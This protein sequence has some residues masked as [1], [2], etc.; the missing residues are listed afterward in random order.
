MTL[1]SSWRTTLLALLLDLPSRRLRLREQIH[2]A[3]YGEVLLVKGR[4]NRIEATVYNTL[5]LNDCPDDLW[6]ALDPEAIKKS[7]RARAAIL[8]GPRYFLMDKISIADP[9]EEIFDF[10]GLQMRRLATVPLPLTSLLGG[11]QRHP[12]TE[13]AVRRTTVYVW[14]QG[15]EVYEL[16]APDGTTYV[17]QSYS[18]AGRSDPDRSGAAHPRRRGCSFP[19]AGATVCA[20]SRKNGCCP[21][22]GKPVFSRMSSRTRTSVWSRRHRGAMS[23]TDDPRRT[24]SA[25]QRT[26]TI[27][28]GVRPPPRP[29]LAELLRRRRGSVRAW[30]R[31]PGS[32]PVRSRCLP[33]A[34]APQHRRRLPETGRPGSSGPA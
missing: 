9:G 14:D 11:L 6:H 23:R 19:T 8:N 13:Q 24:H 1:A 5:G 17:M 33:R 18:L 20:G 28:T 15:R 10:G 22:M 3:R 2:G 4:L 26:A 27:E 29:S 32:A 31:R 12:Y 16:V 34:L 21:S 30:R 25:H 7:Y